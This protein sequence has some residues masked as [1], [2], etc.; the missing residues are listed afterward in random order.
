MKGD[1]SRS[2]FNSAKHYRGVRLQQGRIQLDADWNE[3]IDILLHH[4]ERELKDLIGPY[5][6]PQGNAGFAITL[7]P[8]S[9]NPAAAGTMPPADLLPPDVQIAKGQRYVDGILCIN[10]ADCTFTTQP[11]FP[12]ATIHRQA[13]AG[14]Q[15]QLVYL[16]VWQH[17]ITA[18]EDGDLREVA[19]GGLDTTTRIQTVA[20]VKFWPLP[21]DLAQAG[22]APTLVTAFQ[23]LLAVKQKPKG[24]LTAQKTEK[25]AILQNQ[26]Y[27]I[28]IHSVKGDQVAFK[29]SRENGAIAYSVREIKVNPEN[30]AQLDIQLKDVKSDQIDLRINNWV[31]ISCNDD[32]LDGK[33]GVF[34]KVI[35]IQ[36][37]LQ[38]VTVQPV[39]PLSAL[40]PA[41]CDQKRMLLQ[42]WDQSDG[43]TGVVARPV[44]TWLTLENELQVKF[45][46]DGE[47][48]VGDYWLIPARANLKQG[49][50]DILWPPGAAKPPAGT[51]HHY[52]PLACL[53]YAAG[54]W[55]IV[56]SETITFGTLPIITKKVDEV[57]DRVTQVEAEIVDLKARVTTLEEQMAEVLTLIKREQTSLYQNFKSSVAL[58]K[59]LVVAIDPSADFHV[60]PA[61]LSNE[62]LVLGIVDEVIPGDFPYRV[63]FQGRAQCKVVGPVKVGDLLTPTELDGHA[64]RGGL[65]LRPGTIIGKA[66]R[67][68]L[69]DD[70]EDVG[71]LD[72]MIIIS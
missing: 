17:H 34:G 64:G 30:T 3:Q 26:L 31:E 23:A 12:G 54:Q 57:V 56:D 7:P 58:E 27:R 28:E 60:V 42:R 18:R 11:D 63:I 38:L 29:W 67:T 72:V 32:A 48:T 45:S 15:Q 69:P 36:P 9:A 51:E 39:K 2:S 46:K 24:K 21:A 68:Y 10:E 65:Y 14:H 61:N 6:A 50:G 66:L 5:G 71:L 19:L 59:G 55:Q 70:P 43:T 62:T 33:A 35:D 52:A 22:V 47:Y 1:F 49:A 8:A 25:G 44:D 41:T 4:N 40:D 37:D 53:Q 20:Q 13:M 16:D